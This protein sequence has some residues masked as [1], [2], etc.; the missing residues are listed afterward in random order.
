MSRRRRGS[1]QPPA[2]GRIVLDSG[3]LSAFTGR[4]PRARAWLRWIN[5]HGGNVV[6]PAAV[7]VETVTGDAGRDAETNRVLRVLHGPAGP[8]PIDGRLARLAGALRYRAGGDQA[9]G[10]HGIDALVAAEAVRT[11]AP[12]V[13]LTSDP[14]DLSALLADHPQV[15]VRAV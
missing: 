10:D 13:V 1:R 9:G 8:A 2:D 14:D 6:V 7:L 4:S 3:G 11:Q 5:Q 15:E 12:I